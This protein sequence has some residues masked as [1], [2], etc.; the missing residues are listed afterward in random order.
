MK[1]VVVFKWFSSM[2]P[3]FVRIFI[4]LLSLALLAVVLI[5]EG[6]GTYINFLAHAGQAVHPQAQ[7]IGDIA[8]SSDGSQIIIAGYE[9]GCPVPTRYA[10]GVLLLYNNRGEYVSKITPDAGILQ[11]VKDRYP[12]IVLPSGSHDNGLDIP[13]IAYQS[14]MFSRDDNELALSFAMTI[15][16]PSGFVYLAGLDII[17][18]KNMGATILLQPRNSGSYTEWD[19]FQQKTVILPKESMVYS[20]PSS[21]FPPSLE[22]HWDNDGNIIPDP[23]LQNE[24]VPSASDSMGQ[25]GNPD[26][27]QSFSIWQSGYINYANRLTPTTN[28]IYNP[29]VYTWQTSFAAWS[30]DMRYLISGAT[31]EG[32]VKVAGIQAPS[33]QTVADFFGPHPSPIL[34]VSAGLQHIIQSISPTN[35]NTQYAVSWRPDGKIVAS[36]DRHKHVGLYENKSGK[37]ISTLIPTKALNSLRGVPPVLLWSPNGKS[38]L[39]F[40]T[41]LGSITVWNSGQLP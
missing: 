35:G 40:D 29:G 25:I 20:G 27:D 24:D 11:I 3:V 4:A 15:F 34:P 36:E 9:N 10:S 14:M 7:C 21:D 16:Q 2:K 22:Y 5:H 17:N 13:S 8:W 38:L 39:F 41:S 12:Q 37:L 32:R 6:L 26:G 1:C 31:I 18:L 28:V 23:P 33:A 30:P 19:L